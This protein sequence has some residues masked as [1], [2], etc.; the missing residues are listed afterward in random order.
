MRHLFFILLFSTYSL[1]LQ[2]EVIGGK[3]T[4]FLKKLEGEVEIEEV[5]KFLLDDFSVT[6]KEFQDFVLKNPKWK[7]SKVSPSFADHNYL[8]HWPSDIL[9]E[10]DLKEIGD[11]PVINISWFAANKYCKSLE[12]RLPTINEWEFAADVD[13]PENI[14]KVLL[15]YEKSSTLLK[16]K[17]QLKPSQNGLYG[18]HGNI[19]EWVNDFNSIIVSNDS[20]GAQNS[21]STLNSFSCGA[22]SLLSKTSS[23]YTSFMRFAFRAALEAKYTSSNL[24]FRCAK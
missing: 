19:W 11:K 1:A 24:G 14:K 8:S 2:V 20:R 4:T 21:D 16:T 12:K 15:W 23:N 3:Y 7:K 13:N 18:M 17:S 6:N 10:K 22:A 9:S 5:K